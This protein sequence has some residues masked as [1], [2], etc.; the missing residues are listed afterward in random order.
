[1]QKESLTAYLDRWKYPEHRKADKQI[2][3]DMGKDYKIQISEKTQKR[4]VLEELVPL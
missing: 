3:V 1:V 2:S 4:K